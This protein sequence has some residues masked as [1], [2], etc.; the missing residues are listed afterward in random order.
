VPRERRFP[1]NSRALSSVSMSR[2]A[3]GTGAPEQFLHA[4]RAVTE[5]FA[6]R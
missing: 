4:R 6:D 2:R 1:G 3:I 5:G